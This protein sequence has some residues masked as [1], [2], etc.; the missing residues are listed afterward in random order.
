[1]VKMLG[2]PLA[3]IAT[4][5]A[6]TC[7]AES[8]IYAYADERG[9]L[10]L[11]DIPDDVRY[12]PLAGRTKAKVAMS[13]PYEALIDQVAQAYGVDAALVHAVI[14]V[15]S[16]YNARALSRRGA[17]GLMQ[18]M[19]PTAARYGVSDV[20]DPSQNV[21]AGTQH[22]Q[23]L[24]RFFDNDLELVLAAYNAGVNAV[25]RHGRKIPPYR[26]TLDYVPRVLR[27]YAQSFARDDPSLPR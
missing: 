2:F 17:A 23:E 24:L 3:V 16:G 26:E 21:R 13:R 14:S 15:E 20:F 4:A 10:H 25:E 7:R 1:M 5:I 8:T 18:L 9:V 11:S 12:R 27:A 22:L 6:L 19:A